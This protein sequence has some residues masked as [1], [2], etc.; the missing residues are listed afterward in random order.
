MNKLKSTFV[1][2]FYLLIIPIAGLAVSYYVLSSYTQTL[3]FSVIALCIDKI[4]SD[5][6]ILSACSQAQVTNIYYL[7]V[8]SVISAIIVFVLI[9]SFLFFSLIC[10]TNRKLITSI[11]P[12][13]IPLSTFIIAL[14]ILVQGA[15]LTYGAYILE[16]FL[17]GR[18][19]YF[20]IGAIGLGAL[21]GSL[22]LIGSLFEIKRTLEMPVFAK[23][24]SKNDNQSLWEFVKDIATKLNARI[25]DN[26]V[27]GLEPTFFATSA[28]IKL[29]NENT[30]IKGETLYLSII[31]MKLFSKQ[32]L[33]AVIGHELGHFSGKDTAY[34]MKFAPVYSGLT[35]SINT[36]DEGD[37][38]VAV[39]AIAML[40]AMLDI[41]SRN[42]SKIS[43][44]REF[45]ADKIGVS[46]SSNEDLAV[47]LAKV[48]I[49]ASLWQKVRQENIDRLNEGK[50]SSN[51]SKV[52][53]D[54][55]KYDFSV[56]DINN[57]L[58]EI[59]NYKIIHP[60]DTHPPI[61][62][63]FKNIDFKSESLTIEKLSYV[64]N[65]SED[66]LTNADDLEKDLTLFEHKFLVAVG[67]VAIPENTENENHNFL[68]LIYS[69]VA[70]MI[71]ADGKIEQNEILSAESIGKK[72]FKG[73]DA[74]ELRNFCNNLETLPKIADIV[75]LLGTT[76]KDDD[77]QNIYNYL[78]E[79]ANAD[80]DLA[81]EEKNLLLLIK[82]SW[83]L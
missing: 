27:I 3:G 39:P 62:E 77:K 41:F 21:F 64:G 9:F 45:E 24:V 81:D 78:N 36:L 29:V 75:D 42:V 1:A 70:T 11:F 60:T 8:A 72:I 35:S 54:S 2:S 63:R 13:L 76:L 4:I 65:S 46:V 10:G 16:S 14:Q 69:L 6:E 57:L 61:K 47:S 73:F 34:S 71:G 66:L 51:L 43:R 55:S 52:F 32:Q 58:E 59:L 79:I 38:I 37:S 40:S 53:E 18:V 49:F 17:I 25:P 7:G 15:I 82:D 26:I 74:V 28:N 20:L 5:A 22:K 23:Q 68:N 12:F 56:A 67:F 83:N 80:G 44:S 33:A 30:V 50:I 48:S 19:H 31:L